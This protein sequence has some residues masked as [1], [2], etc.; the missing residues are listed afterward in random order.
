[1]GSMQDFIAASKWPWQ[2]K[3]IWEFP[4][5]T[6]LSM[7]AVLDLAPPEWIATQTSMALLVATMLPVFPLSPQV[8]DAGGTPGQ[9]YNH[10]RC[11]RAQCATPVSPGPVADSV[12]FPYWSARLRLMTGCLLPRHAPCQHTTGARVT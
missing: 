4:A 3:G 6:L 7:A 10:P 1:M 9:H 5:C 8:N 2:A 11:I 12:R